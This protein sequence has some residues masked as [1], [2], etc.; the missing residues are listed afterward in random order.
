MELSRKFNS[1]V[2][3]MKSAPP[4]IEACGHANLTTPVLLNEA[5]QDGKALDDCLQSQ[6]VPHPTTIPVM[7]TDT[8]VTE[9]PLDEDG[10][11]MVENF[12]VNADDTS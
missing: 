3:F 10:L 9:L 8:E 5:E 2:D 6:L 11:F 4:R 12:V 7:Q 1:V